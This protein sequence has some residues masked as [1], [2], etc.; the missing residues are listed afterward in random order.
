MKLFPSIPALP[1]V[2]IQSISLVGYN[3]RLLKQINEEKAVVDN[4]APSNQVVPKRNKK[5]VLEKPDPIPV[6]PVI[7]IQSKSIGKSYIC[8]FCPQEVACDIP[9]LN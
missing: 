8:K 2:P 1:A 4:P 7:P 9:V 6:L 3:Q 5:I